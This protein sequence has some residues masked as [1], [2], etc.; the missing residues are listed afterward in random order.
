MLLCTSP[1]HLEEG[2]G[3]FGLCHHVGAIT[4][5]HYILLVSSH[6]CCHLLLQLLMVN[7]VTVKCHLSR[8]QSPD[9]TGTSFK[10]IR[11]NYDLF[12]K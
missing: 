5:C 7:L 6:G 2:L 12:A 8:L 3:A 9:V 4:C 11:R 1:S 10:Q